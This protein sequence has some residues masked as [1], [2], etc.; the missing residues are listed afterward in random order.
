MP[1]KLSLESASFVGRDFLEI[2]HF[3][4]SEIETILSLAHELKGCLKAGESH[5]LLEGKTLA[6]IFEKP[7]SRTRIS[8]EVG[9]F[10]LGGSAINVNAAEIKM[11]ERESI[12]DVART[13]SRYVDGVMIRALYHWTLEEFALAATV[14]LINGLSDHHHPCQALADIFTVQERKGDL[15]KV[16]ICYVG[17]GNNVCNSLIQIC[18][19]LGIRLSVATPPGHQPLLR[20]EPKYTELLNDPIEGCRDA[21]VIYT[22]VWISMGQE[23]AGSRKMVDFEGYMVDKKMFTAAKSDA[24]FMHC[25][26]AHRG[27]EVEQAIFDSS[28]SVVFDQAENRLHTQKAVL[29][30]LLGGLRR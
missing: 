25:L 15:K 3:T 26:P 5:K 8:F 9:T 27:V 28:R 10:Q 4:P 18:E 19:L 17:D 30:L 23:E 2:S 7:S 22:D 12:A 13:L 11:G 16:K 14:P 29:A 6:M 1:E 20:K 21:D 24:I